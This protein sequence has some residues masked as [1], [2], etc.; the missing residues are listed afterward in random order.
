MKKTVLLITAAILFIQAHCQSFVP[1][2]SW[3]FIYEE[4]VPGATLTIDGSILSEASFNVSVADGSLLYIGDD[5]II[6]KPDMSRVYAARMGEDVFV[7]VMGK[8]YR[9]LSELDLGL[10]LESVSINYDELGKVNI[11][12]G[13]SSHTASTQ[14]LSIIMDGRFDSDKKS[15]AELALSKKRGKDLPLDHELYVYVRKHLVHATKSS[16]MNYQGIDKDEASAFFK[17]EKI[18]FKDLQS[19]EKVV[20]FLSSKFEQ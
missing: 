3:P 4:F 10:V 12:Y 2:D 18:K 11:G 15:V 19:L 14:N 13:V 6:M 9:I 1:M 16:V 8:M 20:V 5:G 17:A 7:N